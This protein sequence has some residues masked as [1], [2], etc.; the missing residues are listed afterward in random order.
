MET[1]QTEPVIQTE[2]TAQPQK[3][4]ERSS[5]FE[6]LRIISMFLI[7][8]H[9]FGAHGFTTYGLL[10]TGLLPATENW[11]KVFLA[12]GKFGVNLF[13]LISGYFLVKSKFKWSKLVKLI[14]QTMFFTVSLYLITCAWGEIKF[15]WKDLLR[16]FFPISTRK[17]WFVEIYVILY[18]LSPFINKV[19][20]HCSKREFQTLLGIL[21]IVQIVFPNIDNYF[22]QSELVWFIT[23]Y[24][25]A[26]YIRLYPNKLTDLKRVNLPVF[27][28]TFGLIIYAYL[29]WEQAYFGMS[30]LFCVVASLSLFCLFKN[31]KMPKIKAINFIAS[32]MLGVYLFHDNL[33]FTHSIPHIWNDAIL[34]EQIFHAPFHAQF[35]GFPLYAFC[36]AVLVMAMGIG[37]ELV[38]QLIFFG[39]EKLINR[40]KPKKQKEEDTAETLNSVKENNI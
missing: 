34:W 26:A 8:L 17:Y 27:V 15:S 19:I 22:P 6:L 39:V 2:N 23:L 32:T 16:N 13:V 18:A 40:L 28:F 21:L 29:V 37:I 38:R 31:I 1:I 5:N 24:L 20:N 14:L 3:K 33:Y 25:I 36:V 9:H 7:I 11:I 4:T 12:I 30:S 10:S 35:A